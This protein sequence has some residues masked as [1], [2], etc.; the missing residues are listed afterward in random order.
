M[1]LG[2]VVAIQDLS[3][4]LFFAF[5]PLLGYAASHA[6]VSFTATLALV[7][8]VFVKLSLAMGTAFFLA[9]TA[10]LP[11]AGIMEMFASPELL[12]L[13]GLAFCM[14]IAWTSDQMVTP[15]PLFLI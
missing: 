5:M 11:I 7:F 8:T 9:R 10:I 12:Q 1:V 3:V 6:S 4:G 2:I 13:C 15:P 14:T